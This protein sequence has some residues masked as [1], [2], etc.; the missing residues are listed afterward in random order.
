MNSELQRVFLEI[1]GNGKI[2]SAVKP[3]VKPGKEQ[4]KDHK[5]L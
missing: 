1:K 2:N 5:Q 4:E 3:E